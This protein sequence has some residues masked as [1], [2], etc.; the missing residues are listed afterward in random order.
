MLFDPRGG[1]VLAGIWGD[2]RHGGVFS[3][4]GP[5]GPWTRL[6]VGLEGREVLSLALH[7]DTIVAGTDAGIFVWNAAPQTWKRVRSVPGQV[8]VHPRVNDLTALPGGS[9]VAATS[10][11]VLRS[12]DGGLTWKRPTLGLTGHVNVQAVAAS[13]R[14][15]GLVLAATPLGFFKSL[16]AG[17]RWAQ[18]SSGIAEVE[19][20]RIAVLP[21]DDAVVFAT[22]SRGLFRSRDGGQ[23]WARVTGGIPEADITGLAVHA[24]GRTLYASDFTWGG[25]F[26]S[27]DGGESW[28]RLPAEGLASDRVW[29]L[30]VDPSGAERVLA[31]SPSGGVHMLTPPPAAA[32]GEGSR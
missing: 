24:D 6:G 12:L 4:P 8:E 32:A 5:R 3:A 11:G 31:A 25:V 13:A 29:A 30:A 15:P 18:T 14:Q 16:D 27:A 26:R 1:R 22:T 23:S 17:E 10:H 7:E 21:T 9:Y 2:R 19:A 28:E 20:H